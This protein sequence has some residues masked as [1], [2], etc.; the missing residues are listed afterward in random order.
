MSK[1]YKDIYRLLKEFKHNSIFFV[2]LK[3]TVVLVIIPLLILL[4]L[5]MRASY[6]RLYSDFTNT[7][8]QIGTTSLSAINAIVDDSSVRNEIAN[9]SACLSLLK[10]STRDMENHTVSKHVSGLKR[11]LSFFKTN[12][13]A[14]SNIILYSKY[15]NYVFSLNGSGTLDTYYDTQWYDPAR[16]ASYVSETT[17]KDKTTLNI[18]S[19]I[20][21]HSKYAGLLVIQLDKSYI[22]SL[23]AS[24][25]Q[26]N[27]LTA[28]YLVS[29]IDGT[30][31]SDLNPTGT[32]PVGKKNTVIEKETKNNALT[33]RM[34]ASVYP[35][36]Y[37]TV[38]ILPMTLLLV[39]LSLSMAFLI[40][41]VISVKF[42]STIRSILLVL[43]SSGE[44]IPN[45]TRAEIEF[46]NK[47]ILNSLSFKQL[48]DNLAPNFLALRK[49]QAL[50]LQS[51]INPHFLFNTLNLVNATIY[52]EAGHETKSMQ[53]IGLLSEL[54]TELIDT[55]SYITSVE[56][57]IEYAKKY[58]EIELI[59]CCNTF[60]V[61]W[62]ISPDVLP[63][64]TIKMIL[65]PIIENAIL[66][67]IK[68]LPDTKRG[69][70]SIEAYTQN[71]C[72]IFTVSDNGNGF[73][74]EQ[75]E[76]IRKK[77]ELDFVPERNRIGV[78]NVHG[79][80]KLIFG[81]GYGLKIDSSEN[82]S[83]ITI[84]LPAVDR[85]DSSAP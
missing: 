30:V 3:Y 29:P 75:L 5:I 68:A 50:V 49:S 31:I 26:E 16:K 83:K 52:E 48:E 73:S 65:Q 7:A 39:L 43:N 82:G 25:S 70:L 56:S 20:N 21:P 77:M 2:L 71:G 81:N 42:Y 40:S 64:Y 13:P 18:C 17:Y 28:F 8:K 37:F 38:S 1:Y 67:G 44:E 41:Y 63:L 6:D 33:L 60:D 74:P 80:I 36:N 61:S 69:L 22:E 84:K 79:R 62:N 47:R 59:K 11:V 55:T 53:I 72:L 85:L 24:G 4:A 58:L 32:K 34:V 9:S 35:E 45:V 23:L 14:V 12:N 54:F 10:Y 78:I 57:E 15:N 27:V 51:Q 76:K 19:Y 46:I 66:H